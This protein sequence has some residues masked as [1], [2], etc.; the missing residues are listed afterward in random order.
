[1]GQATTPRSPAGRFHCC[2]LQ[3]RRNPHARSSTRRQMATE[4]RWLVPDRRLRP[5]SDV[6][7]GFEEARRVE[8]AKQ[9]RVHSSSPS[10][11]ASFD[12]S[13][14]L[15]AAGISQR[16]SRGDCLGAIDGSR[17]SRG[18]WRG[19]PGPER[20]P[21]ESGR[22]HRGRRLR[23]SRA[24]GRELSRVDRGRAQ[25][26]DRRTSRGGCD[27]SRTDRRDGGRH[28][29]RAQQPRS[30]EQLHDDVGSRR[31]IADRHTVGRCSV[32]L[33]GRVSVPTVGNLLLWVREW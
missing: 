3:A 1:M 26:F 33:H 5:R 9:Q 27:R 2:Q 31:R 32:E 10:S 24:G 25:R 15:D 28:P 11:K 20:E 21:S 17:P 7:K 23:S 12:W 8:E 29:G 30:R 13:A 4:D 6:D 18:C 19:V 22:G 16:S 14:G